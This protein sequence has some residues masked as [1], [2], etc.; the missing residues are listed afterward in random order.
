MVAAHSSNILSADGVHFSPETDLS[1]LTGTKN[2]S[3]SRFLHA[4]QVEGPYLRPMQE[5]HLSAGRLLCSPAANYKL[6]VGLEDFASDKREPCAP[7][8]EAPS[9]RDKKR[10]RCNRAWPTE[11]P[12]CVVRVYSFE[13]KPGASPWE[14][15]RLKALP[16]VRLAGEDSVQVCADH[17]HIHKQR[18]SHEKRRRLPE[19]ENAV[20]M[21]SR[22]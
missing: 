21:S 10:E 9:K 19:T 18:R 12:N 7:H 14:N 11:E 16:W 6:Y 13:S 8:S 22:A 4:G 17:L 5:Q 1:G 3:A 20:V 15:R 2:V